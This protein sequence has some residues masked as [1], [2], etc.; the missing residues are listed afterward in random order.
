MTSSGIS[1]RESPDAYKNEEKIK[2][3]TTPSYLPREIEKEV[4][5]E[6]TEEMQD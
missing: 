2:K 3:P 1:K 4:I 5:E 6:V